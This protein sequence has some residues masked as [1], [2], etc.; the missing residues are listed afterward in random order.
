[1]TIFIFIVLKIFKETVD[2]CQPDTALPYLNFKA[3]LKDDEDVTDLELSFKGMREE[4]S[5]VIASYDLQQIKGI[6]M[7]QLKPF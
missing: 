7:T 1:M 2:R 4:T 6:E 3:L 5:L